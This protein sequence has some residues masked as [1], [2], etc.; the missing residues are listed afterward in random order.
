M[1]PILSNT[2]YVYIGDCRGRQF[3]L[4]IK[5]SFLRCLLVSAWLT[6]NTMGREEGVRFRWQGIT[7][8]TLQ[9]EKITYINI[10]FS[11]YLAGRITFQLHEICLGIDFPK[12]TLHVFVCDSENHM[13][14]LSGIYFLGKSH[15]SYTKIRFRNY[16]R[17]NSWLECTLA[18]LTRE[19]LVEKPPVRLVLCRVL[20]CP[21]SRVRQSVFC[22]KAGLFKRVHCREILQIL[23]SAE[24]VTI[25]GNPA[26]F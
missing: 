17:N 6:H 2:V 5:R 20:S 12:I 24:S 14:T 18:I 13:E 25:N 19:L 1:G 11:N 10:C 16:F 21:H 23:E 3:L 15:F 8:T 7:P 22:C 9:S 26:N 4:P